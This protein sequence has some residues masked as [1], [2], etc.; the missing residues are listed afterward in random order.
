MLGVSG[1]GYRSSDALA[2][3]SACIGELLTA[4]SWTAAERWALLAGF[5]GALTTGA[6]GSPFSDAQAEEL[7]VEEDDDD[8]DEDDDDDDDE[9]DDDDEDTDDEEG[10]RLRPSLT[11]LTSSIL[12]STSL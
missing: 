4:L 11:D 7:D 6:A 8:D 1:Q 5:S 12:T 3:R 10:R 9:E 2:C